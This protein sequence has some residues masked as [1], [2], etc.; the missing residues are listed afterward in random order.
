MKRDNTEHN[1]ASFH[2]RY[3]EG[4]YNWWNSGLCKFFEE[5]CYD[6]KESFIKDLSY[7]QSGLDT[8][9]IGVECER[10]SGRG[11]ASPPGQAPVKHFVRR[12]MTTIHLETTSPPEVVSSCEIAQINR[13]NLLYK[14]T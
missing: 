14:C 2:A 1:T 5:P 4:Q 9:S 11:G 8:L 6:R 13:E 10:G 3:G 7:G 12:E